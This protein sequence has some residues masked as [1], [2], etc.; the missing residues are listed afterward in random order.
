MTDD[1]LFMATVV[2]RIEGWLD[3]FAALRTLDLLYHQEI[4]G[5]RGSVYEVGLYHGKYFAL[6][7]RSA[8]TTGDRAV[9]IESF[10]Y[11]PR[12]QFEREFPEQ[13]RL[14]DLGPVE[15]KILA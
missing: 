7:L 15:F 1:R 11:V 10:A 8:A 13:V 3:R 2:D 6:L 4:C 9:G 12:E 5:I 14:S